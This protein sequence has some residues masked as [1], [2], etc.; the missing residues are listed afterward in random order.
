MSLASMIGELQANVANTDAA[1][2]MTLI[3]EAWG[4]VRRL[5]GWSWQLKQTGFTVPG[6]LST[7]T[8]TLQFGVAQVIGDSN[9]SAAW[10]PPGLDRNTDHS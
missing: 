5:G 7:G 6:A 9:A 10:L 8:V 4:D 3:N 1:Y 2:A